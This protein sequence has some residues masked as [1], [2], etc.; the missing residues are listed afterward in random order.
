MYFGKVVNNYD[1]L[2]I[3]RCKVRVIGLYDSLNDDDLPWLMPMLAF[4]SEIIKPPKIGTQVACESLD[5]PYNQNVIIVGIIPGIDDSTEE[6]DTPRVARNEDIA[7]TIVQLK[8]DNKIGVEPDAY[9]NYG[10]IYPKNRVIETESGHYIEID[11]SAGSERINIYHESGSYIEM[12][13][14]GDIIIKGNGN[15]YDITDGYKYTHTELNEEKIVN[16]ELKIT[17]PI[18]AITGSLTVSEGATG[19]FSTSSGTTITV[20]KGIVTNITS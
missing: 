20:H 17:S 19:E 4:N 6:P 9:D 5:E 16:G 2:K 15:S 10:S 8:S 13:T 11:D 3:G 1:P 7:N 12:T 14:S 18:T